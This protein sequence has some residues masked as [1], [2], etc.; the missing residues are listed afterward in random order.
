MRYKGPLAWWGILSPII[1]VILMVVVSG[2]HTT[3]LPTTLA[4]AFLTMISFI[5]SFFAY[6]MWSNSDHFFK[7]I[8]K[9]DQEIDEYAKAKRMYIRKLEELNAKEAEN[10]K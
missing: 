7:S 6:V 9:L 4:V 2:H 8:D 1:W 10:I 3:S 5:G